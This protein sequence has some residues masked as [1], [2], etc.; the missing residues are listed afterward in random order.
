MT[1]SRAEALVGREGDKR[2]GDA[3]QL[4]AGLELGAAA[5]GTGVA[6]L[7]PRLLCDRHR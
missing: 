7:A 6:L 3:E 1:D 5:D 4:V 2:G